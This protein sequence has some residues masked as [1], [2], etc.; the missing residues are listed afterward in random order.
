MYAGRRV[1]FTKPN[2]VDVQ[3]EQEPK[4]KSKEI[5]VETVSTLIS[6]G[7]ELAL[8]SG[9]SLFAQECGYPLYPGYSNAGIIKA[10]GE[11]VKEF[12]VG[13]R[14]Y[15][16]LPHSSYGLIE[17]PPINA[18]KI[19]DNVTYDEA[20]FTTLGAVALYGIRKVKI[21]FGESVL[22]IGAGIVG[23][24]AVQLARLS[25]SF[26]VIVAD[27]FEKR[28]QL[29]EKGG[30]THLINCTST[31]LVSEVKKITK[32]RGVN[33]VLDAT[34]N[35]DVIPQALDS[36]SMNGRVIILG[37]PYGKV[38]FDIF[39]QLDYRDISL[40]GCHQPNNLTQETIFY[41]W[42][43]LKERQLILQLISKGYLKV[44]SLITHRLDVQKAPVGYHELIKSKE[45]TVGV[46]LLWQRG[47]GIDINRHIEE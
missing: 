42:S 40:W 3:E 22:V 6:A 28:L 21:E 14:I 31:S 44:D 7:T 8:L 2:I 32:G 47:K 9:Q 12:A 36:A 20:T 19:P 37:T 39:K 35:P 43:K 29:A 41:P 16:Q 17:V 23:Q 27:L 18:V 25:G 30:A 1:V 38:T 46:V 33:V 26:L 10:V 34:G 13:E 45:D 11:E 15:S 24:L 5:L 4:P